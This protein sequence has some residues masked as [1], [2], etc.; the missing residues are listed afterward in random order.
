MKRKSERIKGWGTLLLRKPTEETVIITFSWS[1]SL[2]WF[3]ESQ[4]WG[5]DQVQSSWI[6]PIDWKEEERKEWRWHEI[7]YWAARFQGINKL[8]GNIIQSYEKKCVA[9]W[10]DGKHCFPKAGIISEKEK[11]ILSFTRHLLSFSLIYYFP[12]S[13][14]SLPSSSWTTMSMFNLLKVVFS[15][16]FLTF[17]SR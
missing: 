14:P 6:I 11:S 7:L 2:S 16:H 8:K 1:Q 4:P 17:M 5:Y 13:V 12:F 15:H 10:K 9:S 3:G